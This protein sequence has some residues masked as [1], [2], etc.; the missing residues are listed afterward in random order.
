MLCQF[1]LF[2]GQC[3]SIANQ[4]KLLY[5][6]EAKWRFALVMSLISTYQTTFESYEL[7]L[8]SGLVLG[9]G[10]VGLLSCA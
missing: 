6:F 3:K 7:R 5:I 4:P 10:F 9:S 8:G 1:W 2:T